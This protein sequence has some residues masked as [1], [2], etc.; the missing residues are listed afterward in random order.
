MFSDVISLY[1]FLDKKLANASILKAMFLWDG[2]RKSGNTEINIRV[3]G[4]PS[5]DHTW[6][7]EVTP[8]NDFV[9]VPFPVNPSVNIDF[10]KANT[11][12]V[13]NANFFRYVSSPIAKYASGGEDN[14]KVNFV[15]FG[16]KP[17]DLLSHMGER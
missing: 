9:F 13:P 2:S 12:N 11:E 17:D 5:T 1:N 4:N 16:Y 8:Y 7:Y 15:V 10:G 3:H 14:V 6:F